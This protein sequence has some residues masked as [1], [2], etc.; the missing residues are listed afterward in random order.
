MDKGIIMW[1]VFLTVIAGIILVNRRIKSGIDE[2]GIET[3]AVVSRITDDG[4]PED[5]EINVYVR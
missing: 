4:T 5:I 1:I 3:D 2:N